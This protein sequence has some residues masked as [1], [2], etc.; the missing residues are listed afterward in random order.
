MLRHLDSSLTLVALSILCS[1]L[2][3]KANL[4]GMKNI[5]VEV[6]RWNIESR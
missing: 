6:A 4:P 2:G 3:V 5:T 1:L